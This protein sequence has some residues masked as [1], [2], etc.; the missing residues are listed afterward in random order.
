[1]KCVQKITVVFTLWL[2]ALLVG[3]ATENIAAYAD[4]A[5][6]SWDV[7]VD[8]NGKIEMQY[9]TEG[10]SGDFPFRSKDVEFSSTGGVSSDVGAWDIYFEITAP[11]NGHFTLWEW[12]SN[13]MQDFIDKFPSGM[14]SGFYAFDAGSNDFV[15]KLWSGGATG[16]FSKTNTQGGHGKW[17][18]S[19]KG[20]I[21]FHLPESG[22]GQYTHGNGV[23]LNFLNSVLFIPDNPSAIRATGYQIN[24]Y[25]K[26]G[27][28]DPSVD[29]FHGAAG[30]MYHPGT[31]GVVVGSADHAHVYEDQGKWDNEAAPT[32]E[33]E[34]E[35]KPTPPSSNTKPSNIVV[36]LGESKYS[37]EKQEDSSYL[38]ILPIGTDPTALAGL[39]LDISLPKGATISPDAKMGVDFSGGPVTFLIT[40]ED[41]KTTRTLIIEVRITQP[42]TAEG[43][44][45]TTVS[46]N[47]R[48][49]VT[50]NEDGSLS[51]EIQLP[52]AD[53]FDPAELDGIHTVQDGLSGLEFACVDANGGITPLAHRSSGEA[54]LRITGTAAN[55]SAMASASLSELSYWLEGYTTEYRQTFPTPLRLSDMPT[56]YNNEPPGESENEP[57]SG[58]SSGCHTGALTLFGLLLSGLG[59]AGIRRR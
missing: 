4:P 12:N 36:T 1:M 5:M 39:S 43:E 13:D 29:L 32:P 53:T 33:P 16:S 6:V 2:L 47:C 56:T 19:G 44:A 51:L 11:D 31:P 27:S 18:V 15:I 23:V 25:Y 40:A 37:A 24:A 48:V 26:K 30:G 58:G 59:I 8:G 41:K 52:F 17:A 21:R 42:Q 20:A 38:I 45:V 35:P 28:G 7:V 22:R 3:T 46:S 49:F 34:P 50:Y 10:V 54:Y 9:P 55:E 57:S 14:S